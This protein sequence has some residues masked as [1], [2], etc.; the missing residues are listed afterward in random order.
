MKTYRVRIEAVHLAGISFDFEVRAESSSI[1]MEIA[2]EM[3]ER[4]LQ[5]YVS[6]IQVV[7]P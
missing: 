6:D 3:A 2:R 5:V 1:A 7:Y 4:E